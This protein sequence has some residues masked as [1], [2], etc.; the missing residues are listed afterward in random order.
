MMQSDG[1][2]SIENI[3]YGS[4][5]KYDR[6][7]QQVFNTFSNTSIASATNLN[8]F[9][10]LYSVL[11][12]LFSEHYRTDVSDYTAI[13]TGVINMCS[14]YRA[15]FKRLSVQTKFYL[16]FSFNTCDI[17]RKFVANYNEDFYRKSQIKLFNDLAMNNF[18]LLDLLCPYLPDIF[19]IKSP[20]NFESS[21]V[22]ANLIETIN[23][24]N[25][26]LII[27]KD[28][29]P[30]QL[31]YLYPYTSYLYPIKRKGG[32][33][34]SIMI[35]ISEKNTFRYEFWNLISRIRKFD[36][37]SIVDVSP[38]NYPLFC[39]LNRFPER[40]IQGLMNVVGIR[41]MIVNL[42]GN[43]DVK[44]ILQQLYEDQSISSKLQVSLVESRLKALD[45][46]Y[47]YPYYKN[48]PE[49]KCIQFQNLHDD[50]TVNMI[51]S[52]F[53]SHNPIDINKL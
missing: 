39:A 26:N 37:N 25:P 52:K 6:L 2:V 19:F 43:N 28:I 49:S 31:C 10:D 23:D 45:I 14:H 34:E 8:I 20:R 44:I 17:N 42:V 24:G 18:D 38:V 32:I 11:K 1:L 40:M 27:S 48:D 36:V 5:V 50:A 15:F 4:F 13:T 47:I 16:I 3:I 12:S 51:N 33:D 53:F 9:I 30:L 35:P 41:N 21:I 29:Y 46:Q 7:Q 22:I